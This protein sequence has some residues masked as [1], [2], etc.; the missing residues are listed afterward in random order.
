MIIVMNEMAVSV[1]GYFLTT[2]TD[3]SILQLHVV[4]ELLIQIFS[5][6]W[7]EFFLHLCSPEDET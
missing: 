6:R 1:S 4:A 7:Q 3:V 2:W 5:L